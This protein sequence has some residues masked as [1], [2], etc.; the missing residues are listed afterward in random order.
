MKRR[1][2]GGGWGSGTALCGHPELD[3]V[4]DQLHSLLPTRLLLY[5]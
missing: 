4:P 1:G 2:W 5:I 3:I